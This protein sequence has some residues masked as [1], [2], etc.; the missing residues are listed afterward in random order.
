MTNKFNRQIIGS[1]VLAA[2][3]LLGLSAVGLSGCNTNSKSSKITPATAGDAAFVARAHNTRPELVRKR[4]IRHERRV[5]RE[6]RRIQEKERN[7][8]V[9]R[10]ARLRQKRAT[11]KFRQKQE[12]GEGNGGH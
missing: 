5:A 8:H 12:E 2:L 11:Q 4:R 10:E 7:Q 6:S 1:K 9:L 3:V